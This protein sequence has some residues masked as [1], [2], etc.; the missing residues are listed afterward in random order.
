[1]IVATRKKFAAALK[2][3]GISNLD[4]FLTDSVPGLEELARNSTV[5]EVIPRLTDE[6]KEKFAVALSM[7]DRILHEVVE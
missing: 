2:D 1:M 7:I 3:N 5:W 4:D 6:Q